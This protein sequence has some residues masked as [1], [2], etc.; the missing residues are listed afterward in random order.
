MKQGFATKINFDVGVIKKLDLRPFKNVLVIAGTENSLR[1]FETKV[2]PLIKP[3]FHVFTNI[4]VKL[5]DYVVYSVYNYACDKKI[6]CILSVGADAVMECGRL[7]GLLLSQGG[8]LHEYLPGQRIGPHGILPSKVHH[9]TVPTQI[10]AGYEISN[11]AGF[12]INEEKKIIESPNLIPDATYIDPQLMAGMPAELWAV[13]G[14]ECFTTALMAYVSK[15]ANPTSDAYA[16]T[17]LDS[18]INHFNGLLKA[19][20]D[21]ELIKHAAAASINSFLAANFSSRGAAHAIAD[22]LMARYGFR[23]GVALAIVCA[24]VVAYC[25]EEAS[26]KLDDVAA[27][28]GMKGGSKAALKNAIKKIV[29]QSG[30]NVPSLAGKLKDSDIE[31]LA[32]ASMNYAMRGNAKEMKAADV[33]KLLRRLP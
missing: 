16:K 30:I 5:T 31:K 2:K 10:A 3:K 29:E 25:Y 6:D 12:F 8:Y 21:V 9:I 23:Y 18:Y 33:A 13:R 7:I 19:P 15:L 26:P 28:L 11:S 24:E 22:A 27:M 14:F 1:I 17:A 20:D 32:A 4:P